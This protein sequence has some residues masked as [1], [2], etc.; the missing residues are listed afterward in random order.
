MLGIRRSRGHHA[1]FFGTLAALNGML[2]GI[3][4]IVWIVIS[5]NRAYT[6]NLTSSLM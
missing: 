1:A 6:G 3:F 2:F 4:P 5:A